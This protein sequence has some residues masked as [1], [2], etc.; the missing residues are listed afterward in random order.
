MAILARFVLYFLV[1]VGADYSEP[2]PRRR[3]LPRGR[4]VLLTE[5]S[6]TDHYM[7]YKC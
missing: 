7:N 4:G 1:T 6:T 2:R 3:L 5:I